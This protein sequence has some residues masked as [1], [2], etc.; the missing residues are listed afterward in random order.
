[1]SLVRKPT[2][3]ITNL[4]L[5]SRSG[6]E[7]HVLTLARAFVDA[8]WD[9]TYYTLVYAFPL[10]KEFMQ[11]GI[12][13]VVFGSESRLDSHYDV[14]FAQHRLV[15]EYLWALGR[16]TF[17]K[18]VVSILGVVTDHEAPPSFIHQADMIVLVSQE[19]L[20]EVHQLD[21]GASA[22]EV[23]FLNYAEQ[24]YFDAARFNHSIVLKRI[25][26]VSNHVPAEV[27]ELKHLALKRGISIDYYGLEDCSIDITPDVLITYDVVI[28][29]GRTA[30]CCFA[31]QVP[32]YC[33]DLFGGPGYITPDNYYRHEYANYSGRSEPTKRSADSLLNDICDGY[34]RAVKNLTAMQ[35]IAKQRY[36]FSTNFAQMISGWGS[37][38]QIKHIH[39]LDESDSDTIELKRYRCESFVESFRSNLGHAQFFFDISETSIPSE[40]KSVC[41]AFRYN[42]LISASLDDFEIDKSQMIVRFDPDDDTCMCSAYTVEGVHLLGVNTFGKEDE[43]DCFLTMDPQYAVPSNSRGKSMCRSIQFIAKPINHFDAIEHLAGRID[44]LSRELL[45]TTAELSGL[46]QLKTV[47]FYKVI[48]RLF[49]R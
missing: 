30:Q 39:N 10:Q 12:K 40:R 49:E 16:R 8:G 36:D 23:V 27:R 13:V 31:A 46:E 43:C 47:K 42:S 25:A 1:M 18:V 17:G 20:N 28:S 38:S 6:S 33:Y 44:S 22:K 9:V 11:S 4:Y 35:M 26:V 37:S 15:S 41:F 7:L 45:T 14:L 3:L 29:I 48:H 21:V 2:V 34:S 32:F 5:A 19:A 24:I